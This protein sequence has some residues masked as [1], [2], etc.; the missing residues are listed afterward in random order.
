MS[1]IQERQAREGK[2]RLVTL[3]PGAEVPLRRGSYR[4]AEVASMLGLD[5]LIRYDRLHALE[6][7]VV[8][9][10]PAHA[11][12]RRAGSG[13]TGWRR[14]A[15]D[16]VARI[17]VLIDLCG[18]EDAFAAVGSPRLLGLH[19]VREAGRNLRAPKWGYDDPLLQVPLVRLERAVLAHVD[20]LLVN[21]ITGQELL[22]L[23][24]P[25]KPG[26]MMTRLSS[27]QPAIARKVAKLIG[28][29]R[30]VAAQSKNETT[31]P[32]R[33]FRA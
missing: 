9:I 29:Q 17:V 33:E 24:G 30:K 18:G 28:N 27:R 32:S 20:G 5:G 31:P 26:D 7:V 19:Q 15:L 4:V 23:A 14:Y 1:A 21:P 22:T 16:D 3:R 12:E 13:S 10:N 6:R 25:P 11:V 8:D 2:T